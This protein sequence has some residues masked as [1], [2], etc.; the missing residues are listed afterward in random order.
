M[1][2]VV[3]G[4]AGARLLLAEA[5]ARLEAARSEGVARLSD[6]TALIRPGLSRIDRGGI[7]LVRL[8]R[9]LLSGSSNARR[10][11]VE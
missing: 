4:D 11:C 8:T 10:I 5:E 6:Q 1:R 9:R 3:S 2:K 7:G